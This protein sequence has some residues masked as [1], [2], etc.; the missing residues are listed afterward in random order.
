MRDNKVLFCLFLSMLVMMV[1]YLIPDGP[2]RDY[3]P[4]VDQEISLQSH[5]YYAQ[6]HASRALIIFALLLA[7]PEH[8]RIMWVFFALEIATLIDYVV[9]YNRDILVPGFDINTIK[10]VVYGTLI[11]STMLLNNKRLYGGAT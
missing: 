7:M 11:F 9:R 10:L 2:E 8:K 3:F 6:E 4:L 5:V 1:Y